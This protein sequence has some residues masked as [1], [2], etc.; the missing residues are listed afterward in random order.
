[1]DWGYYTFPVLLIVMAFALY[2]WQE[3]KMKKL[4][5]G[6]K[7][8]IAKRTKDLISSSSGD[9][10]ATIYAYLLRAF[11]TDK[12]L[13][14]PIQQFLPYKRISIL[15]GTAM[16]VATVCAIFHGKLS[17]ISV[18]RNPNVSLNGLLIITLVSLCILTAKWIY[19]EFSYM[20]RI[21]GRF[22]ANS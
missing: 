15:L 2:T 22:D 3:P 6:R 19:E 8:L 12:D 1:M 16:V 7:A 9:I 13:L 14:M 18:L 4:E 10:E 11:E 5:A 20:K 21:I 17:L